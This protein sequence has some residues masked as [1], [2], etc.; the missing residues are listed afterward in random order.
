MLYSVNS[1]EIWLDYDEPDA[2][3]MEGRHV[4]R[5]ESRDSCARTHR[6]FLS[7]LWHAAVACRAGLESVSI[8][9]RSSDRARRVCH[10]WPGAAPE[11]APGAA[12]WVSPS[13][14]E[15]TTP[16]P[17]R[18]GSYS[19]LISHTDLEY[20]ASDPPS[21]E[22]PGSLYGRN[23]E[24]LCA[25]RYSRVANMI[26][27]EVEIDAELPAAEVQGIADQID[28]LEE[29]AEM[30]VQVSPLVCTGC[31]EAVWL[32]QRRS[33]PCLLEKQLPHCEQSMCGPFFCNKV[34]VEGSV[35]VMGEVTPPQLQNACCKCTGRGHSLGLTVA[36]AAER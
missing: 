15:H 3:R 32:P 29:V 34:P 33:W 9:H 22:L 17:P 31:R 24:R 26:E 30:Q 27:I 28:R 5:H 21:V 19:D 6:R 10:I 36:C 35:R 12:R 4:V 16:R 14:A 18:L 2:S 20:K 7:D 23:D 1:L 8:A 11:Q 13:P 25:C